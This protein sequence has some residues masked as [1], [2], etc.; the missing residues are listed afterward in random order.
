MKE[1]IL[2]FTILLFIFIDYFNLLDLLIIY[3]NN[4]FM[5]TIIL[6]LILYVFALIMAQFITKRDLKKN[7]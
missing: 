5:I 6:S 3:V 4:G 2:I 7:V 1:L